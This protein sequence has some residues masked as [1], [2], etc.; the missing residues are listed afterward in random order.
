[1]MPCILHA[2][3]TLLLYE[4]RNTSGFKTGQHYQKTKPPNQ[5]RRSGNLRHS[6][7]W[8]WILPELMRSSFFVQQF[9]TSGL[10]NFLDFGTKYQIWCTGPS[11]I[12]EV[13]LFVSV[14]P[15]IYLDFFPL[16]RYRLYFFIDFH[17]FFS[18]YQNDFCD[19]FPQISQIV[20]HP[21]YVLYSPNK[22]IADLKSLHECHYFS[23]TYSFFGIRKWEESPAW[24]IYSS[25]DFQFFVLF[26]RGSPNGEVNSIDL[27]LNW[28]LD[29]PKGQTLKH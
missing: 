14:G 17:W 28:I 12:S 2:G 21:T 22:Y 26:S 13:G 20:S 29:V 4:K 18:F 8:G 6:R 9:P 3:T 27:H 11:K 10:L 15:E 16:R 1:M 5:E 25:R 24:N 23:A 19:A 7:G